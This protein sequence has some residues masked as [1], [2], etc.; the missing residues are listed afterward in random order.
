VWEYDVTKCR[1]TCTV[2]GANHFKSFDGRSFNF[3]GECSYVL[4][5]SETTPVDSFKVSFTNNICGDDGVACSRSVTINVGDGETF[6]ILVLKKEV[7][8]KNS[9]RY[10]FDLKV[11]F[12]ILLIAY[13]LGFTFGT[14]VN[15]SLLK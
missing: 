10:F 7:T 9:S 4:A 8:T 12:F 11:S 1:G 15:L 5:Q 6:E 3:D 13:N 14:K 2:F